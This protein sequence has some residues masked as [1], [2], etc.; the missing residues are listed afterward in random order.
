MK[1]VYYSKGD[2]SNP[3]N[4]KQALIDKG[5][6][7][8]VKL[9]YDR[10]DNIYYISRDLTILCTHKDSDLADFIINY[11]T[12]LCVS[13]EIFEPF[14]KVIVRYSATGSWTVGI[15]S[16]KTTDNYFKCSESIYDECHIY[17]SWMKPYLGTT[18]SW[19]DFKK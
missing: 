12:E 11:G 16:H 3:K 2:T 7:D 1:T 10:E 4:V 5:G 14:D 6:I 8:K 15:Y 9:S 19:E 13:E 17:E 18:T